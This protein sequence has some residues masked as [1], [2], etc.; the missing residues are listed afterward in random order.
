[1]LDKAIH[2]APT[3]TIAEATADKPRTQEPRRLF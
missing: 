2:I 3:I 1:L